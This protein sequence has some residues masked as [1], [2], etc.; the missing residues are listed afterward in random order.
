M[1]LHQDA[2]GDTKSFLVSGLK[3]VGLAK[4]VDRYSEFGEVLVRWCERGEEVLDLR[5]SRKFFD[6]VW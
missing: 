2:F 3:N 6:A 1:R 5:D 4:G